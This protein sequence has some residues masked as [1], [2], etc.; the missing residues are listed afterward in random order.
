MSGSSVNL[1]EKMLWSKSGIGIY[2]YFAY[3]A[4]RRK[5]DSGDGVETASPTF[6]DRWVGSLVNWAKGS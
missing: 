1:V 4:I 6:G 2:Q 3:R 5:Q